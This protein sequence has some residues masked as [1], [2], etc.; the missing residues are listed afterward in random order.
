MIVYCSMSI[1]CRVVTVFG[2][3]PS[4]VDSSVASV[5]SALKVPYLT[6]HPVLA[7]SENIQARKFAVHLGPSQNDL[8]QA[9]KDT[10]ERLK[11]SEMALLSHRETGKSTFL[12]FFFKFKEKLSMNSMIFSWISK[13]YF[14]KKE[15][16][17]KNMKWEKSILWFYRQV[18]RFLQI[19]CALFQIF[20]ALYKKFLLSC[21]HTRQEW[22]ICSSHSFARCIAFI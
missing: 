9:V 4:L 10:I 8:I 1:S 13:I 20:R 5:C 2:S 7:S 11:W 16:M 21:Y 18:A 12:L 14:L 15:H 17:R 6:T 3:S 19:V 22:F